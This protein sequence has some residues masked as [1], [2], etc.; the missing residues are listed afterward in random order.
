[1]N[2]ALEAGKEFSVPLY[3]SALVASHMDAVLA[4]GKGEYDHS[5]LALLMEQL[6]NI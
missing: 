3:G 5:S 4:S 6:A 1:M 2:I